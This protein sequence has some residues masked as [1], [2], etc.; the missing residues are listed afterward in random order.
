MT[1]KQLISELKELPSMDPA[2]WDWIQDCINVLKKYKSIQSIEQSDVDIEKLMEEI[3]IYLE[4]RSEYELEVKE[5]LQSHL[6]S[7]A[8][9]QEVDKVDDVC[10]ICW[11]EY[12]CAC[13]D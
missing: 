13:W 4:N 2:H 3:W 12:N 7:K 8:P 5:I 11:R 6:T 1:I 9:K 10:D